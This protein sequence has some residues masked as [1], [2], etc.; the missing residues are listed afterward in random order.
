[1]HR[2]TQLPCIVLMVLLAPGLA[3]RVSSKFKNTLND[4]SERTEHTQESKD[5]AVHVHG[6]LRVS[7]HTAFGDRTVVGVASDPDGKC[8]KVLEKIQAMASRVGDE[9]PGM[10]KESDLLMND[11]KNG[12]TGALVLDE[13]EEVVSTQGFLQTMSAGHSHE[14]ITASDTNILL[15]CEEGKKAP[16][17]ENTATNDGLN[18][19]QGDMLEP[20]ED[21]NSLLEF[22][23]AINNGSRWAGNLWSRGVV[24]W[25]FSPSISRRAKRSWHQAVEHVSRQVP[26]MTFTD[27]GSYSETSCSTAPSIIVTSSGSGCYSYVGNVFDRTSMPGMVATMQ[28]NLF[29]RTLLLLKKKSQDL[30]LGR[31]CEFLGIA[32]HELGH[33]LGMTHEQSRPDREKYVQIHWQNMEHGVEHNFVI[34]QKA[35]T[36][37]TYDAYSLMHYDAKAFSSNG[38]AT[39]TAVGNKKLDDLLLGQRQGFSELDVEQIAQMY[40]CEGHP[41]L[42]NKEKAI[43]LVKRTFQCPSQCMECCQQVISWSFVLGRQDKSAFKCVMPKESIP[44]FKIVGRKCDAATPRDTDPPSGESKCALTTAEQAHEFQNQLAVCN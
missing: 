32:A 15:E 13:V 12:I 34:E 27:V 24:S 10:A 7:G 26:C 3:E 29:D 31:G 21:G 19:V 6:G 41:E 28:H 37:T 18:I 20:P 40:G 35:F 44:G 5:E 43:A 25:C 42:I 9:D 2:S 8:S 14:V 11:I 23:S 16:L 36:G 33:A 22:Q 4:D 38:Y 17:E 39:I 1:M 30:N